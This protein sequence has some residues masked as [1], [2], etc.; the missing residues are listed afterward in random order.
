MFS[1]CTRSPRGKTNQP[2][3]EVPN[4]CNAFGCPEVLI[5]IVLKLATVPVGQPSDCTHGA[6]QGKAGTATITV[7]SAFEL[8]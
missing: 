1:N 8:L 4:C 7:T 3:A 2:E 6:A 5:L